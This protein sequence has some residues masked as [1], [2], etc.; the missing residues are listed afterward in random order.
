MAGGTQVASL[1]GV[2]SLD[3]SQW[4]N[5][6]NKADKD[7]QSFGGR[8][9]S[10]LGRAGDGLTNLGAGITRAVAPLAA[11]G[12]VG[13]N[14]AA[15]FESAMN[16]ISARTG[17]V[18]EDLESIRQFSLK[19]GADTA[20]SAQQAADA[21]LQLLSS[22]SSA[23]EAMAAL[24]AVLD[25][26]AASGMDLGRS[27]DVVT[28]I[29]S[30]FGLSSRVASDDFIN[31]QREMGV[32]D[33]VFT[34]FG[35]NSEPANQA[36]NAM[37]ERLNVSTE[38]LYAM[39]N[40][41]KKLTP[42]IQSLVSSF[43]ISQDQWDEYAKFLAGDGGGVS[44]SIKKLIDQTGIAG[45]ALYE[46][47]N[48]IDQAA[49]VADVLAKAAGASSAEVGDLAQGFANVG[50]VA[51]LF[52]MS[53]EDTAAALAVLAENGIKGAEGGT[54]LKSMLLNLSQPTDKV[55][56]ALSALGVSLYD[57]RGNVRN[58]DDIIDDLDE[59]LNKLSVKDQIEYSKI[60]G[61][62]YGIVGLNA[63]RMAGGIDE[64]QGAMK[65]A[66][67]A[68]EVA[69]ARM[70]GFAGAFDQLKGSVETLMISAL[71]PFMEK[72]LTPLVGK[73]TDVVNKV[74]AWAVAN[75]EVTNTIAAIVLGLSILGPVLYAT[76][77]AVNG[78]TAAF[79]LMMSPITGV[80]ILIG[81]MV[82]AYLDNFGGFRDFIDNK[83]R[84][85]LEGAFNLIKDVVTNTFGWL[86]Q[87]VLQPFI[88]SINWIM[89]KLNILNKSSGPSLAEQRY[90]DAWGGKD[91]GPAGWGSTPGGFGL[92]GHADGG[93]TGG[94][95]PN[96]IAGVV[97]GQEW[98]IPTKGGPL[99]RERGSRGEQAAGMVFGPG[100]VVIHASDAAGG[101]RAAEGFDRRLTELRRAKGVA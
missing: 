51:N 99:L 18:G 69:D 41:S 48:P 95:S 28:D 63:L 90:G 15:T 83:V 88:D 12:V 57:V 56:N 71:T 49:M 81:A 50:P 97:H 20:F 33:S 40:A 100:S 65:N 78:I 14:T 101:R 86:Q 34:A 23:E 24:P 7:A 58:I 5:K 6:L 53:V 74:T 98:V 46:M 76:G 47:I 85:F 77:V 91:T 61:G 87:Y 96:Q 16:E 11:I 93:W 35:Q 73:I 84:P 1:F 26:A 25:L 8:L 31:L 72:I 36:L 17:I 29:M 89:D 62:S 13:I 45:S 42:E 52:Q 94:G 38:E 75:P 66:A 80:I 44:G 68:S 9:S 22:G 60:L 64:M 3:D 27:A 55:T 59:S 30:Q 37:A 39:W 4:N 70:K 10:A 79:A 32:A 43:G 67:G 92:P 2:L 21:F 82:K 19:M 54:A